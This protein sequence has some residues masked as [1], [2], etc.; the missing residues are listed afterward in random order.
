MTFVALEDAYGLHIV[1][2]NALMTVQTAVAA[3]HAVAGAA[4]RQ[5]FSVVTSKAPRLESPNDLDL[6]QTD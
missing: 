2:G 1:G 6:E 4:A 3:M 5:S